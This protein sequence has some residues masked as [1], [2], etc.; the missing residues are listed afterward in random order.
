MSLINCRL[1]LIRVAA[2]SLCQASI[3]KQIFLISTENSIQISGKVKTLLFVKMKGP[4]IIVMNRFC[5]IVK[6]SRGRVKTNV[7]K[8]RRYGYPEKHSK[9]KMNN[10][11]FILGLKPQKMIQ[12]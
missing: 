10:F 4:H 7:N 6:M 3:L 9:M 8:I 2:N 12:F 1:L 5:L 11:R